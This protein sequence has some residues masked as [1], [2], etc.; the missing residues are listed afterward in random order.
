MKRIGIVIIVLVVVGFTTFNIYKDKKIEQEEN[1]IQEKFA[2]FKNN[3]IKSK[4]QDN[5]EKYFNNLLILK[6]DIDSLE[7]QK[8]N[9]KD[10]EN[11]EKKLDVLQ[12]NIKIN[13]DIL[14]TNIDD[15][16]NNYDEKS[17]EEIKEIYNENEIVKKRE[18]YKTKL[19]EYQ[20]K[21]KNDINL[22]N[23]LNTN[24]DKYYLKDNTL[25]YK[26]ENVKKKI[27]NVTTDI[28]LKKEAVVNIPI[29]M[30]HG[31]L[32]KAYGAVELFVK[33]SEFEEQM[34]YLKENNFTPIFLSEI[35]DA[36]KYDKPILIT[37][38]DGYKDV[39]T[40][41]YPILKKYNLKANLYIITDWV[42]GEVYVNWDDVKTLDASNI[43][44]IGSHTRTHKNL[45]KLNES[46]VEYELKGSKEILEKNLNKKINT[47]AYPYG[48]HNKMVMNVASKYYAY[49]LSTNSGKEISNNLNKYELNRYY[50][51]R[52]IA[53]STFKSY[54]N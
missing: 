50:I 4:P 20:D 32:D 17:K 40:N 26:N 29:L 18:E 45:G 1:L 28:T 39:Y 3:K 13:S 36:P 16:L 5:V 47:I 35:E 44:E 49:A 23:Y 37:F 46:E 24:K 22:L 48:G 10:L 11:I 19:K 53:M 42:G 8:I 15:V 14:N 30:Y 12:E 27:E 43:M 38:D 54:V 25:V 31:V 41:A 6:K 7:Y 34:K 52:G 33:V 9:N 2:F 21:A 51:Y